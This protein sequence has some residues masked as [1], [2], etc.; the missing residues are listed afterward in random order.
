MKLV[1][2]GQDRHEFFSIEALEGGLLIDKEREGGVWLWK[3]GRF[4]TQKESEG[5]GSERGV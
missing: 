2:C 5:F 3:E 1:I 4:D